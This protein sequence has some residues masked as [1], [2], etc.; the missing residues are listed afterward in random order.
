M[1]Q[2]A[3]NHSSL[4][5]HVRYWVMTLVEPSGGGSLMMTKTLIFF[6]KK[7]LLYTFDG[8]ELYIEFAAVYRVVPGRIS[9]SFKKKTKP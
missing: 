7:S 4:S 8:I 3:A 1:P 9:S 6:D 2:Q 5:S